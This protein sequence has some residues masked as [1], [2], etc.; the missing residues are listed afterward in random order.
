[1][2]HLVVTR[3]L[4]NSLYDQLRL[5]WRGGRVT[6]SDASGFD[7]SGGTNVFMACKP[8]S[9]YENILTGLSI[10]FFFTVLVTY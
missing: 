5:R 9:A 10:M 1:M 2:V 3:I 7:Y 4:L 8:M 6:G